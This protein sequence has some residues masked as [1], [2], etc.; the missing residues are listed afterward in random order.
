[1]TEAAPLAIVSMGLLSGGGDDLEGILSFQ[2]SG[3]ADDLR[4]K[5]IQGITDQPVGHEVRSIVPDFNVRERL[6]RKGTSTFDRNTALAVVAC[7]RALDAADS[8][9]DT[10]EEGRESIG[11]CL[12][13]TV[14]SFEST[15][16]FT[17]ETLIHEKPYLV[18]PLLFPNTIMNGAAGQVAIR[19]GLHGPNITVA[20]GP[21]AFITA[22][23]TTQR[24]IR[25]GKATAMIVAGVEEF[26]PKRALL[27]ESM[28]APPIGEAAVAA[29]VTP[30]NPSTTAGLHVLGSALGFQ[31]AHAPSTDALARCVRT[32]IGQAEIESD[33]VDLAYTGETDDTDT[34][35]IAAITAGLGHTPRR[36]LTTPA[37]GDCGAATAGIATALATDPHLDYSYCLVTGRDEGG[38]VGA[39]LLGRG[40]TRANHRQ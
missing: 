29:V 18:N 34:T 39:M 3:M 12:G 30:R 5:Q 16:D 28:N 20:G 21:L 6:G 32:V 36:L 8:A 26:S 31:P 1:M 27:A 7:T 13:T 24:L 11:V 17:L 19:H 14:G 38:A 37:F 25:L 33:A 15:S 10:S 23:T 9:L 4:T 22:M 40:G 35:Q 2:A